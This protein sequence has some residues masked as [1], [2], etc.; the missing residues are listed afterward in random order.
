MEWFKKFGDGLKRFIKREP[1]YLWLTIFIIVVN[2]LV[3]ITDVD[4]DKA[5][6]GSL[7]G[8]SKAER[9]MEDRFKIEKAITEDGKF[10][11]IASFVVLA[12]GL[13]IF[14]GL[15][16]DF[17]ILVRK[18]GKRDIL[19]RSNSPSDT[20]WNLWDA[21]KIAILFTFYGYCL[22]LI[23]GFLLPFFSPIKAGDSMLSIA[24]ATIMDLVGIGLVFYFAIYC[25]KH[26][27]KDL[28]LT[29]KGL[30]KNISYGFLGYIS[31]LPVL[32]ITLMITAFFLNIFK[33]QPTPQPVF[34]L[35]LE[36]EKVPVLIYLSIFVAILG[37]IM[38]EIFFRGFLYTA[39][40]RHTDVTGAIFI[41]ALLFSFLHLHLV[42]FLPIVILGVFLAYLYEKTGSLVPC[43]TVHIVHNLIMV[44]FMF[45]L[46]GIVN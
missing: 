9:L 14:I 18:G 28:G 43:I 36:V 27:F 4:K 37:P 29:T 19:E 10:A 21:V 22:A 24:N 7:E 26:K 39:L 45:L 44:F 15:I 11:T 30:L 3:L 16:L 35:F 1:V 46:K 32:F 23:A 17:A 25:Y 33:Y 12:V 31:L 20:K 2:I 34:D 5:A 13:S 6:Q 8:P 41:S 40:K 42:G 38:E